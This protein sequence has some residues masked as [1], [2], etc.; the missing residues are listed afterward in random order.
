MDGRESRVKDCLQQ[1]KIVYCAYI[2]LRN[3]RVELLREL[4]YEEETA[5][6]RARL[7]RIRMIIVNFLNEMMEIA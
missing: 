4:C 7:E 5:R 3:E 2:P 1:P 6:K